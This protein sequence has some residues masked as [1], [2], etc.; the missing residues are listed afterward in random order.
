MVATLLSLNPP[1]PTKAHEKSLVY[2]GI[3]Y[4]PFTCWHW[5]PQFCVNG[6][7]PDQSGEFE[8]FRQGKAL[9]G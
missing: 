6:I 5:Q 1:Q 9:L 8:S 3:S 4:D 7:L 2:F